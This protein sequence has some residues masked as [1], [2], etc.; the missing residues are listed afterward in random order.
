[1]NQSMMQSS[2]QAFGAYLQENEKSGATVEKYMHD[3]RVFCAFL[4][5]RVLDR[6]ILLD[7]KAHLGERYAVAS[8]NS[9]LAALNA[10]LRFCGR[11]ELC[12]KR[13]TV[14]R[15]IFCREERELTRAEYV[16]LLEAAGKQGVSAQ[17]A[18]PVRAHV[19]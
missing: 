15:Q 9:M 4:G 6:Q 5:D 12:V 3:V 7:Y 17:S 1:M 14:Q 13:F 16:R 19:L 2:V 18:P 8:A 10:Y 11:G